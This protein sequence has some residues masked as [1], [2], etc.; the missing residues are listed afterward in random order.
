MVFQ[1]DWRPTH[2]PGRMLRGI[3]GHVSTLPGHQTDLPLPGRPTTAT[4]DKRQHGC[5]CS[6]IRNTG[7]C[8]K[9]NPTQLCE[10]KNVTP[11]PRIL[12]SEIGTS[13]ET[14]SPTPRDSYSEIGKSLANASPAPRDSSLRNRSVDGKTLLHP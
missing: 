13:C 3:S 7:S 4:D 5:A 2:H 14:T 6:S 9:M 12:S 8:E 10:C 1:N 11:H